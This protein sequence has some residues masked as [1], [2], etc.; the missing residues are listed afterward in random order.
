MK[1]VSDTGEHAPAIPPVVKVV[2]IQLTLT[3]ILVQHQHVAVAVRIEHNCM[4]Y[5]PHHHPSNTLRA[6][7]NSESKIP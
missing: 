2:E 4:K 1:R 7:S 5:H 3:A 6:E